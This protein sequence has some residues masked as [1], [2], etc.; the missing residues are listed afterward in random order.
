MVRVLIGV[1][2]AQKR[3]LALSVR[4]RAVLGGIVVLLVRSR[5]HGRLSGGDADEERN[6]IPWP[7]VLDSVQKR[8][9]W[10][11]GT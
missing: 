4:C 9:F 11:W 1:I 8:L 2:M 5:W 6:A 10:A 3:H 7:C